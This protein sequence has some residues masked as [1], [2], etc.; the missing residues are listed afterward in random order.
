M[1]VV[2]GLGN[3]EEKYTYTRHNAGFL[4][5]DRLAEKHGFAFRK[6]AHRAMIAE[7]RIGSEKVVLAK[8]LTYMNDS[9]RS[10]VD[11]I[12]WYKIDPAEELLV[13]YDDIDLDVGEIRIRAK[14]SAGSHNGM[15]SIIYLTGQDDFPRVRIG[16]GHKPAAWDLADYVLSGFSEEEKPAFWDSLA[17]AGDAVEMVAQGDLLEAQNRFNKRGKAKKQ[18]EE[19]RVENG[20]D[21]ANAREMKKR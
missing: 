18:T 14:G 5:L 8:P 19:E 7:G 16:I 21:G 10:A 9:G 15:K 17:D 4:A 13:L 3:P 12:N 20:S 6:E 11:L 2:M 1:L